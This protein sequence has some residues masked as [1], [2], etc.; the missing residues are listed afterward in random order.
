MTEPILFER[1]PA[2]S[3]RLPWLP[4]AQLPTPVQPVTVAQGGRAVTLLVKRDDLSA[5]PYGGNKVRKLEFLLADARAQ[6]ATRVV[7]AG[8]FGSHH[9]L[10]TTVFG[11][12]SGFA[13]S[14]VLFP[15]HRTPHVQDILRMI[16]AH[17]AELRFT[18]RMEGVPFALRRARWAHRG[19]RVCTIPPGGSSAVGTLGYVNAALELDAQIA[20]GECDV[21][22]V[23]HVA[24]GTLGTAAGLA[25]GLALA[26]RRIPIQAT[27]ITST[28]VTNPRT[29]RRLL[30]G[31]AA[32]LESAGVRVPE[33]ASVME[34]VELRDDQIGAG[35]GHETAAGRAAT[36][37]FRAAG[38]VLDP[39]YTAKAAA[40]VLAAEATGA[41]PPLFWH[42]LSAAE[43]LEAARG[44][45]ASRLPRPF[46]AALAGP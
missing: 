28:L 4:L 20:A 18:R 39:T 38:L 32:L 31:A 1:Y 27:R 8:A 46:A 12:R 16:A 45:D 22:S 41:G 6:G 10:A 19:E 33:V 23:I 43:P 26:G 37:A 3:G 14:C 40:A 34:M 36:D 21:P 7:T 13:V 44:L 29:L 9:A 5:R 11:V 17:G 42:T 35:Y 2:L 30:R 24:G 15:Q 25:L